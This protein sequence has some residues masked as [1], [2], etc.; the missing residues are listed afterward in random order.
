M[1]LS[2]LYYLVHFR[3]LESLASHCLLLSSF[4]PLLCVRHLRA[5]LLIGSSLGFAFSCNRI[6]MR[7]RLNWS[8]IW[9]RPRGSWWAGIR[10]TPWYSQYP[11]RVILKFSTFERFHKNHKIVVAECYGSVGGSPLLRFQRL[12][13][14]PVSDFFFRTTSGPGVIIING[15]RKSTFGRLGFPSRGRSG[16][17]TLRD[18][19]SITWSHDVTRMH[20]IE[21]KRWNS[22]FS[23]A[24]TLCHCMCMCQL[25]YSNSSFQWNVLFSSNSK[26]F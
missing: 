16:G 11:Y 5:E 19:Y 9:Q 20:D 23:F 24:N 14:N 25:Y 3:Y 15:V 8:T 21:R 10:Q 6:F 2:T 1:Y 7:T 22:P 4:L 18:K 26:L 17:P 13:N 12:Q